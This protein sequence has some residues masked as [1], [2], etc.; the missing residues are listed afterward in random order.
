[1]MKQP[2]TA[3]TLFE[4]FIEKIE[5]AVEALASQVPYTQSK[6]VSIDFS[7]VKNLDIYLNGAKE[8]RGKKATNKT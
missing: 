6:I 7:L 2:I 8:L 1:M 5:L 4:D 3:E